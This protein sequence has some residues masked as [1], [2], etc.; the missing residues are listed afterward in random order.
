M[1]SLQAALVS[2]SLLLLESCAS[3]PADSTYSWSLTKPM[4]SNE[5]SE[6]PSPFAKVC[7]GSSDRPDT[8]VCGCSSESPLGTPYH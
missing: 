8:L 5:Q 3:T 6:C 7:Y 2:L 4:A 1:T